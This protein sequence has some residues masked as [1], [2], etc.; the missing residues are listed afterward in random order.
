MGMATET[1][2]QKLARLRTLLESGVTSTSLDGETT[3]F[4]LESVR[5]EIARLETKT[6]IRRKR[7]RILTLDMGRR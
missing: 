1:D 2:A 5:R 6:G 7:G 4:D 3:S